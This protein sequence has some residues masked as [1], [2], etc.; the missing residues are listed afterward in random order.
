MKFIEISQ[1]L[2]QP[3]SNEESLV[4]ERV[5]GSENSI[6]RKKSLNLREQEVARQL[7]QRGVL[8]RLHSQ[9]HIY[10]GYQEP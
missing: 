3:I 1:G 10:Y 2:L 5:K 7:C 6:C 8:T 4:L 9:G